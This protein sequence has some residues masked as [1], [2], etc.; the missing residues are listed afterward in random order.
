MRKPRFVAEAS[1]ASIDWSYPMPTLPSDILQRYPSN[2]K[3]NDHVIRWA[4][5]YE[6]IF[7]DLI[8]GYVTVAGRWSTSAHIIRTIVNGY[9]AT[10]LRSPWGP[11]LVTAH[12]IICFVSH[13]ESPSPA[14]CV[15]HKNGVK[16]DNRPENLEWVTYKQNSRHCVETGLHHATF[17]EA[18]ATILTD[19]DVMII[20]TRYS[21]GDTPTKLGNEYGTSPCYIGQVVRGQKWKHLPLVADTTTGKKLRATRPQKRQQKEPL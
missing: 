9:V 13:G 6:R 12:R 19:A 10:A 15:N 21:S 1:K 14:H 4:L 18:K 16:T 17:G 8:N 7:V 11:R 3:T 20:R 2:G 5:D